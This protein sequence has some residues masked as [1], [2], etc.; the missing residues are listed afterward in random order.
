[1][2]YDINKWIYECDSKDE[3]RYVLGTKG[4]K[5]LLCFGI[6]PSTA[7]PEKL[8]NTLK[9]VERLTINNGYDSWI[10]MNVYPQ[11]ATD[12]NDIHQKI[13]SE[14][15]RVNLNHIKDIL[16][17]TNIDI[18]AAWG[19]LIEKRPFLIDCLQDIYKLTLDFE[20]KWLTI[21]KESKFGHPHHPLYLNSKE[22][23]R[24]FDIFDY[25][26]KLNNLV[27]K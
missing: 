22:Q 15:H 17:N 23:V 27:S 9:S 16:K 1:M 19:T 2:N 20:S 26:N 6:N 4:K 8:D 18:W 7:K 5:T 13:D 24:E 25:M 10:M 14:I 12:P 21:G 11:R 3:I